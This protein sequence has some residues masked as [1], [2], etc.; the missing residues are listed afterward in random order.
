MRRPATVSLALALTLGSAGV[1]VTQ[2][3]E[4]PRLRYCRMGLERNI[5]VCNNVHDA[6]SDN[7][8]RCINDSSSIYRMCVLEAVEHMDTVGG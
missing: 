5:N 1:A 4:H 3:T 7:W 2:E 8:Q 6:F